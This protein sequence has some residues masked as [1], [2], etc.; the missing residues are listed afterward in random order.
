MIRWLFSPTAYRLRLAV[1]SAAMLLLSI[2]C[3]VRDAPPQTAP[4]AD[5]ASLEAL[6]E[7][8]GQRLA[9]M[10]QVAEWKRAHDKPVRDRP[11]EL[12]VLDDAVKA[13]DAAA[14]KAGVTPFPEDA[15]RRFYQAQIDTAVG[16]QDQVLSKPPTSRSKPP[17]LDTVIRPELL[18]LGTRIAE[19]LVAQPGS[20]DRS[21]LER[22]AR[23]HWRVEGL[24][25]DA[26]R[27]LVDALERLLETTPLSPARQG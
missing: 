20:P 4:A 14:N 27:H 5:T 1:L 15:V 22:L 6:V 12:V 25:P 3:A 13:V 11:R 24:E 19:L 23:Q 7:V 2:G 16:I 21:R 9:V 17:D 8:M 18:R 10:P 26:V